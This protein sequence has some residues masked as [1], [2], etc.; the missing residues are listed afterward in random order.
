VHTPLVIKAF[1]SRNVLKNQMAQTTAQKSSML[2]AGM[3]AHAVVLGLPAKVCAGRAAARVDHEGGVQGP[4]APRVVH[5]MHS[6]LIKAGPPTKAEGLTTIMVPGHLAV[7]VALP[8]VTMCSNLATLTA[9][10]MS[11]AG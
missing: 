6:Q 11:A 9:L 2:C 8:V 10:V 3:Q 4:S 5:M 1:K 7:S